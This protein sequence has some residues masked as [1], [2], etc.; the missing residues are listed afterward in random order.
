MNK[1]TSSSSKSKL[2]DTIPDSQNSNSELANIAASVSQLP[3]DVIDRMLAHAAQ[4]LE[5][6][7]TIEKDEA[8]LKLVE[9]VKKHNIPFDE[10][11]S[12]LEET[13]AI[14][15]NHS[16]NGRM[17]RVF[18]DPTNPKNVWTGIGR[19]PHW[20]VE[21]VGKKGD[22]SQ[23]A[24]DV[25]SNESQPK[26]YYCNPKKPAQRW[27]GLGRKPF[28]FKELENSGVDLEQYKTYF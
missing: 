19:R 10:I 2:L 5:K 27:N 1:Q 14:F 4:E 18:V 23:F 17:R 24:V 21:K 11:T 13:G 20:I 12:I 16:E 8:I 7:K 15:A 25:A 6:R 3:S 26:A 28:W 9:I 22:T